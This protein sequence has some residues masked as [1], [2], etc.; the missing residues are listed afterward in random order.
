MSR[1]PP[2]QIHPPR[3]TGKFKQTLMT[4]PHWWAEEKYD[5]DRRICHMMD[6]DGARYTGRVVSKKDGLLVEKTENLPHLTIFP[7]SLTGTVLDGEI[8]SPIPGARSR[9]VTSIMGSSPAKAIDKQLARGWLRYAA[10]DVLFYKGQD[11]RSQPLYQ[12]RIILD[13][14]TAEWGCPHAFA[15]PFR[16]DKEALLEEVWGRGGEGIIL[17]RSDAPYGESTAWVK[18]KREE[19]Y[20]VVVMGF[21]PAKEESKKV[22]GTISETKYKGQ[23]GKI[24]F[25][26]YCASTA[27]VVT[28]VEC[29]RC[30]GFDDETRFDMTRRPEK[31]IGRAFE[32]TAQLREPSGA[33]RHPRFI[34]WRDDKPAE[35]CVWGATP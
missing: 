15:V 18:V 22:D 21:E 1:P 9:D 2:P 27:G 35:E 17:K 6:A 25:G 28:V 34:Q 20:D 5:G 19:S 8:I 31:Y 33:F 16:D 29:G 12:R 3:A 32:I 4:D 11:M 26:Q 14:V 30:S 23:V 7:D 24:V 13:H 10:F